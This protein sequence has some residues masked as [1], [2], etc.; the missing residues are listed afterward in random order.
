MKKAALILIIGII[1]NAGLTAQEYIKYPLKTGS[2]TYSLS[3]MGADNT[4]MLYFNNSGNTQCSEVEMEVFGMKVHTRNIIKNNTSYALDMSQKTYTETQL[5][6]EDLQKMGTYLTDENA[7]NTEGIEKVGEETILDKT[8]QIYKMNKDG[9]EIKFWSW[10]GLM[11][12]MES[13]VQ[14][15][16]MNMKATAISESSPDQSL[17][18]IPSDFTKN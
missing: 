8:C 5:S 17:F 6:K 2:V 18:E 3:M 16:S 1:L 4:I 9:A 10:K 7:A 15:M 14:G 11:L 13:N 12:K